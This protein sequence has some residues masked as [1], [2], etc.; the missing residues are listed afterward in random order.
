MVQRGVA[1]VALAVVLAPPL[2]RSQQAGGAAEGRVVLSDGSN[3]PGVSVEILPR[4][5]N[6]SRTTVTSE[7]GRWR[8]TGLP[9]GDYTVRFSLEGFNTATREI[10]LRAGE[11]STTETVLN[12]TVVREEVAVFGAQSSAS[13]WPAY[14]PQPGVSPGGTANVFGA[15][16]TIEPLVQP[17]ELPLQ[18]NLGGAAFRVEVG[19]QTFPTYPVFVT[20]NQAGVILDSSTPTGE[21]FMVAEV[22]GLTSNRWRIDIVPQQPSIYTFNQDGVGQGIFTRLDFSLVTRDRPLTPD[23]HFIAW[24]NGWGR[25]EFDATGGQFDKRAQYDDVAIYF[26]NV[27]LPNNDLLYLGTAGGFAGGDQI[28]G[29]TP[30]NPIFGCAVPFFGIVQ[31]SGSEDRVISNVV[32]VPVSPDGLPCGDPSG[33]SSDQVRRLADG[34]QFR[35]LDVT[36]DEFRFI[37]EGSSQL[38]FLGTAQAQAVNAPSYKPPVAAGGCVMNWRPAGFED[39]RGPQALFLIDSIEVALP[40]VEF[41]VGPNS[42]L[43]PFAQAITLP[44]PEV[45]TPGSYRLV[46]PFRI[47]PASDPTPV[48][49]EGEYS[50]TAGM[51]ND[52]LAQAL[53]LQS[54]PRIS[55]AI[56]AAIDARGATQA[57][58][59]DSSIGFGYRIVFDAGDRGV[60]TLE[61]QQNLVDLAADSALIGLANSMLCSLAPDGIESAMSMSFCSRPT[62]KRRSPWRTLMS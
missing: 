40:W 22:E 60:S 30:S 58:L 13:N 49:V 57:N 37:G 44:G 19:D 46:S 16:F 34:E 27:T 38:F 23:E 55:D 3:V 25:S 43:G 24:G 45:V 29:R 59:T 51:I 53:E 52:L 2:V 41:P 7:Q 56:Q 31:P 42:N 50:R 14:T 15:G 6:M 54:F 5:G 20:P 12:V 4:D 26:G 8:A 21:G 47:S 18:D 48:T 62:R 9:P 35:I 11:T 33:L 61:C 10:T 39:V 32:T 28:I 17:S 1:I 36:L